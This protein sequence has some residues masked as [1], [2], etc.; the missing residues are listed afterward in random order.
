M[1]RRV[2][3]VGAG[4]EDCN[5]ADDLRHDPVLKAAVPRLPQ[6]GQDLASQ[7]TLSRFEN[8][9]GRR[10]LWQMARVLVETFVGQHACD[11]P[12]PITVDFDATDDPT[13]GRQPLSRFDGYCDEQCYLALIMTAQA[14]DG[15]QELVV[16]LLRRGRC[17]A[18]RNALAVLKRLVARFR[19]QWPGVEILMRAD[20]GFAPAAPYDWCEAQATPVHGA[21]LLGRRCR[22]AV[23]RAPGVAVKGSSTL[24]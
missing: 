7:P 5:D 8:C 14:D 1:A 11:K 18:S 3:Q 21:F 24:P 17:H 13:H 6:T 22:R 16:A 20:S 19:E 10:Q 23:R 12:R 15:P 2:Y 9:V 4:Y